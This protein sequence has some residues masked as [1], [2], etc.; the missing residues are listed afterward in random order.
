VKI[1]FQGKEML[2]EEKTKFGHLHYGRL[3]H[4]LFERIK[5][6]SDISPA[7]DSLV[8]EGLIPPDDLGN[9]EKEVENMIQTTHEF[10]WFDKANKILTEADIILPEKENKRPDRI[11]FKDKTAIVIDYKFGHT[12]HQWHMDQVNEYCHI[13]EQMGFTT[14][15]YVWYPTKKRIEQV[16]K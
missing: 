2:S 7:I 3:M 8:N 11:V 13:L 14:K 6:R 4:T 5:Y 12:I 15:G 10:G 16:Q 1:A 9:L